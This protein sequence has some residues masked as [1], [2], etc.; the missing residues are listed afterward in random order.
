MSNNKSPVE[1]EKPLSAYA[2]FFRDTVGAIKLQNP[3]SSF[4]ELSQIVSSMWLALDPTHK[5]V[6][7]KKNEL[8][9]AEYAKALQAYRKK[10][11]TLQ[12]SS[13][14]A[15]HSSVIF[16][17]SNLSQLSNI[18]DNDTTNKSATITEGIGTETEKLPV[19]ETIL[20]DDDNDCVV[21]KSSDDNELKTKS[22]INNKRRNS[23]GSANASTMG[24]SKPIQY[25]STGS[26]SIIHATNIT[27]VITIKNL[28]G[29]SN[30]VNSTNSNSGKTSGNVKIGAP[31]VNVTAGVSTNQQRTE[32]SIGKAK[33]DTTK[34]VSTTKSASSAVSTKEKET[35]KAS[36]SN[37]VQTA[38]KCTR[39]KCKKPAIVN[40]D[41]EDEYCSNE[42]VILHCRDVF[43]AWVRSNNEGKK[44]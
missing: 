43:N 17:S 9:C 32:Q 8:A 5:N 31:V 20:I 14:M 28:S 16:N 12:T 27:K 25:I 42:C 29:I 19:I 11:E 1:P 4:K 44:T 30:T 36:T 15:P 18:N 33:K 39:E 13:E 23:N 26:N 21:I 34:L 24:N 37:Q 22:K 10:N 41:W 38:Q 35:T 7:M 2:L 40:P 3:N 6:Y